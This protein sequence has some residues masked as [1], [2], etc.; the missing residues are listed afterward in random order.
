MIYMNLGK[1]IKEERLEKGYTQEELGEKVD[2]TGG[3]IGQIE[4]GERNASMQKVIS[5][6]RAL[7]VSIDYLTDNFQLVK[8]EHIDEILT[9]EL[10]IASHKQKEMIIDIIKV[11][12][13]Y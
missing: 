5:I 3:Y 10:K 2:S 12:K 1:K 13:K 8:T 7:N 11:L 4:R 6:A 9:N